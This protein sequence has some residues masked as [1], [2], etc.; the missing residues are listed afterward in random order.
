MAWY[1]C[2][3]PH[4]RTDDATAAAPSESASV[5]SGGGHFISRS[6]SKDRDKEN[7]NRAVNNDN[8][9]S[10]PDISDSDKSRRS[11]SS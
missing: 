2:S 7:V 1:S 5:C 11:C 3:R 9:D 8:S 4:N 6:R 10:S